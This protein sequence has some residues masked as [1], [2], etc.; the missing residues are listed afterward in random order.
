[1]AAALLR[2]ATKNNSDFVRV[3]FGIKAVFLLKIFA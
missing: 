1:M 3:F 2:Y